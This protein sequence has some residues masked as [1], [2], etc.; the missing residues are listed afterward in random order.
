MLKT[1]QYLVSKFLYARMLLAP[2]E[3]QELLNLYRGASFFPTGRVLSV[4]E[5]NLTEEAIFEEYQAY[6]SSLKS[7]EAKPLSPKLLTK[8]KD[9]LYRQELSSGKFLFKPILPLIQVSEHRLVVTSDGRIEPMVYGSSTVRFG[10]QFSFPTLFMDEGVP[11]AVLK[12][13]KYLNSELFRLIQRFVRDK[14]EPASFIVQGKK[15]VTPLRIGKTCERKGFFD[16]T[17]EGVEML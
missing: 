15:I 14:T 16:L 9:A 13:K 4:G 3:F 7:S 1:D 5:E 12:E 6:F 2:L 11:Q 8:D 10:V 17:R